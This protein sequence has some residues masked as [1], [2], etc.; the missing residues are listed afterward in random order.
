MSVDPTS[1]PAT[2]TTAATSS[3]NKKGLSKGK[4]I[5]IAAGAV[6][7]AAAITSLAV[8]AHKGNVKD[9]FTKAGEG[10]EKMGLGEKLK[11]AGKAIKKGYGEL[12]Q[13]V[14]DAGKNL[15]NKFKKTETII[16]ED[17]MPS[18]EADN[19]VRT[20]SFP[21]GDLVLSPNIGSGKDFF[22]IPNIGSGKDF[23]NI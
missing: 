14:K 17:K 11:E 23:F 15:A 18:V 4:K 6:V 22:N 1:T 5:A 10:A 8:A 7:G 19:I 9:I 2:S 21:D 16:V 3:A 20:A 13:S 12:F